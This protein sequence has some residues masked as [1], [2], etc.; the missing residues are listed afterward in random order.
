MSD[1]FVRNCYLAILL[2]LA[3]A[4]SQGG[5]PAVVV[6]KSTPELR[7]KSVILLDDGQTARAAEVNG[8]LLVEAHVRYGWFGGFESP[9]DVPMLEIHLSDAE[10][11]KL[12]YL[13]GWTPGY[14][15]S[16]SIK[17]TEEIAVKLFD[18]ETLSG[19]RGKRLLGAERMAKLALSSISFGSDCGMHYSANAK[20]IQPS[21]KGKTVALHDG[22]PRHC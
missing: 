12:P 22:L 11:K 13:A 20:V 10:R 16:F 19:V 8:V 7:V 18:Q 14:F 1:K 6:S 5:Q 2:A 4:V 15:S 3:S 21:S 9:S 17:N